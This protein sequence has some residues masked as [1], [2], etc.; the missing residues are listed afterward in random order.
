MKTAKAK[1]AIGILSIIL[2]I[3]CFV[4]NTGDTEINYTYGGDAY[5]GIQNAA[6]QTARNV[7]ALASITKVGFGS[8]LLISGCFLIVSSLQETD[9]EDDKKENNIEEDSYLDEERL[10]KEEELQKY[11]E[12]MDKGILTEEEFKIKSQQITEHTGSI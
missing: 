7:K 10:T 6:A 3:V 5:T 4:L 1:I 8:I 2:A 11:K 9:T 12:L